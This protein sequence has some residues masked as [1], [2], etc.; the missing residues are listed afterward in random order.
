MR[1]TVVVEGEAGIGKSRPLSALIDI[2][3]ESGITVFRGEAHALERTRPFGALV[4]ALDQGP[5]LLALEDVHW[6]DSSTL[7]AL[8]WMSRR[9]NHAPLLVVATLRPSPRA[10]EL[11]QLLDDALAHGARLIRL[12]PLDDREVEAL[13][14]AARTP[15]EPGSGRGGGPSTVSSGTISATS[16][17][18]ASETASRRLSRCWISAR[19]VVLQRL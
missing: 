7:L 14:R 4:E 1:A 17:E 8:R 13:V 5:V 9:L 16:T 2:A 19:H 3:R 18:S 11:E 6:A 12:E 15:S 10:G